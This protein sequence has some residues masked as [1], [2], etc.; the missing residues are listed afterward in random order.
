[1]RSR[2][3]VALLLSV[4]CAWSQRA[5][6][7][8]A[9]AG[10]DPW[11]HVGTSLEHTL[12]PRQLVLAGASVVPP[13]VFVP[14][15]IDHQARVASQRDL[16]GRYDLEPVSYVTPYALAGTLLIGYA[17]TVGFD[18]CALRRPIVAALQAMAGG[19]AFT[20]FTKWVVGR[21]WPNQGRDPRAPDRLSHPEQAQHFRP[22]R[23]GFG[24][25]PSGHTLSMFAAASAL[26]VSAS[27]AGWVAWLG[28]PLAF[29]VGL[30]MW[31]NDR[32]W[33]SDVLS[34]GLLGEAIGSSAG[35]S[36]T[37]DAL[38]GDAN[39]PTARSG[40]A[41]LWVPDGAGLAWSGE[42]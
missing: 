24:A 28:Y 9:C 20:A 21:E 17:L 40:F 15:G 16:G 7:Q 25:W 2:A 31:L 4:S 3:F 29:G 26:R 12:Q 13:L 33:A 36:F 5:A 23:N 19:L 38:S 27:E 6:A 1:M 10:L 41:P 30:G 42:F 37:P 14:T 18:D 34:G 11:R 8:S 39:P 22:F 35:A 32:H